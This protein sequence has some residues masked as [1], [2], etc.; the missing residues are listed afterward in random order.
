MDSQWKDRKLRKACVGIAC[1]FN[2]KFKNEVK[3][4]LEIKQFKYLF[5]QFGKGRCFSSND[6]NYFHVRMRRKWLK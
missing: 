4:E 6:V 1:T 5:M 3:I 2:L